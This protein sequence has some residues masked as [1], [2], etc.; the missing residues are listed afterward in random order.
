[1]IQEKDF[2]VRYDRLKKE[3]QELMS[4]VIDNEISLNSLDD[5]IKYGVG[6]L[7]DLT[8]FWN[9]SSVEIKNKLC[10]ILFP[11]GIYYFDKNVGTTNLSTI[12][13]VFSPE[14]YEKS[15]MVAHRGLE[16]LF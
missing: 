2:S 14:N 1:M 6:V 16:P 4:L 7:K 15:T 12:L 5:Y 8:T 9:V 3:Q 11:E 13:R 10:F